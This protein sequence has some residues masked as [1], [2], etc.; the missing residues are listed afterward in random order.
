MDRNTGKM[1]IPSSGTICTPTYKLTESSH[2]SCCNIEYSCSVLSEGFCRRQSLWWG[3]CVCG[4]VVCFC[5]LFL[6]G[7][8]VNN[9]TWSYLILS[10]NPLSFVEV[11]SVTSSDIFISICYTHLKNM[12]KNYLAFGLGGNVFDSAVFPGVCCRTFFKLQFV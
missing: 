6:N 12:Y 4:E 8:I 5:F 10:V 3:L 2:F 11:I 9:P 7:I 1:S